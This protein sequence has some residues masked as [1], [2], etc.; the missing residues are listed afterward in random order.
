MK[1][2]SENDTP[3]TPK[4]IASLNC[5]CAFEAVSSTKNYLTEEAEAVEM[6]KNHKIF[7]SFRQRGKN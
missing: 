6:F 4:N 3:N 1:N 2:A 5:S 7:H